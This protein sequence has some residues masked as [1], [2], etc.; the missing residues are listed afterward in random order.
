MPGS[1]KIVKWLKWRPGRAGSGY[2][3]LKLLESVS[4]RFDLYLLQYPTDSYIDWHTDPTFQGFN[5]WRIN[6]VLKES[7][8]GEFQIREG[9]SLEKDEV[10]RKIHI[11][12]RFLNI[13]RPDIQTHCVTK[14]TKGTRYVLS[15]GFLRKNAAWATLQVPAVKI[16]GVTTYSKEIK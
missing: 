1:Q 7:G 16:D 8:G 9:G 12:T 14:V 11:Q 15:L 13:F 2:N 5:H 6:L 4:G 3:K 10:T